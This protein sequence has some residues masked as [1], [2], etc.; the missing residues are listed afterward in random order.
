MHYDALYDDY[1]QATYDD[2]ITAPRGGTYRIIGEVTYQG[3]ESWRVIDI[4]TDVRRI[5]PK[6]QPR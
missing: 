4:K 2:L 6:G 5:I 3:K 1:S